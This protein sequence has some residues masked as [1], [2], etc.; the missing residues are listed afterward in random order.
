MESKTRTTTE[1]Q[2]KDA[3]IQAARTTRLLV[4]VFGLPSAG[5]STFINSLS[6][7]RY[8]DS[9]EARTTL[10]PHLVGYTNRLNFSNIEFG[11]KVI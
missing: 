10:E 4:G 3:E 6:G 11:G 8:L 5:K 2:D 7:K 9:G 1:K